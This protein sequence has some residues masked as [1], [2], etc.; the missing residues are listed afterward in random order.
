MT[1][2]ASTSLPE[3]ILD[4]EKCQ[5]IEDV[6]LAGNSLPEQIQ[7]KKKCHLVEVV[8]VAGSSPVSTPTSQ[9]WVFR[10]TRLAMLGALVLGL[11]GNIKRKFCF[12]PMEKVG[13][14]LLAE[15]STRTDGNYTTRKDQIEHWWSEVENRSPAEHVEGLRNIIFV[16]PHKVGSS[17]M[18][19]YVRLIAARN[20]GIPYEYMYPQRKG[21]FFARTK[22]YPLEGLHTWANHRPLT[23]LLTG[24]K[25]EVIED[26]FKITLVRDPL[27]RCLS[28][29][30]WYKITKPEIDMGVISEEELT[31]QKLELDHCGKKVAWQTQMSEIAPK[32]DESSVEEAL[33][34]YDLIGI[35]G[36]YTESL[37]V[38]KMLLGLRYGDMLC[39]NDK[40]QPTIRPPI[41]EEP[42]EV[43]E[44]MKTL[45]TQK[46]W[47]LF[48]A[49]DR[50]LSKI[51]KKLQ[52]EFSVVH[53]KLAKS[54]S[55]ALLQCDEDH[56][57]V[58][59]GYQLPH[60]CGCFARGNCK[61]SCLN[62]YATDNDLWEIPKPVRLVP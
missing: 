35:T 44:H 51:I 55:N 21:Y 33:A 10:S 16:K 32:G 39:V 54:I 42:P 30:Y 3:H 46:D 62:K 41:S 40:Y 26:S 1:G 9:K 11:L 20:G 23:T 19:L 13:E 38:M 2:N 59:L 61:L 53:T 18:A 12:S 29:F 56:G 43:I 17:T 34:F 28:S 50:K 22:V 49:A 7:D 8:E 45:V 24:S 5:L 37:A 14:R 4:Q 52:P 48:K 6:E 25:H 27:D 31:R 36:R 57:Q 58:P 60:G 47:D 15:V